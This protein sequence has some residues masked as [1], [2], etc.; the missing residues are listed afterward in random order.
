MWDHRSNREGTLCRRFVEFDLGKNRP[1]IRLVDL[2]AVGNS[3]PQ[4]IECT[5]KRLFH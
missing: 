3:I 4:G 1:G 5:L 2:Q